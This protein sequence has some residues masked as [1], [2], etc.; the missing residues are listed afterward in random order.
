MSTGDAHDV[1]FRFVHR[2][3]G[4]AEKRSAGS[5]GLAAIWNAAG[6]ECAR[7]SQGRGSLHAQNRRLWVWRHGGVALSPWL[8][9]GRGAIAVSRNPPLQVFGRT[10]VSRV[11]VIAVPPR[12]EPSDPRKLGNRTEARRSFAK[13]SPNTRGHCAVLCCVAPLAGGPCAGIGS[14]A[15]SWEGCLGQLGAQYEKSP[16][17]F[18]PARTPRL[19]CFPGNSTSG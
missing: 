4:S 10:R 19:R 18:Q 5:S 12:R 14:G 3:K 13:P 11:D 8:T 6:P 9:N 2:K 1:I 15:E 16:S 7:N 17:G